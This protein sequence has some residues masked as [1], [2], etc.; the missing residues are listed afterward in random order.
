MRSKSNHRLP[1]GIPEVDHVLGGGIV[2]GN[3]MLLAGPCGV[4]RSTLALQIAASLAR[5]GARAFVAS[6]EENQDWIA[7]RARRLRA[8]PRVAILGEPRGIVIEPLL[9]LARPSRPKLLIVDSSMT[10]ASEGSTADYGRVAQLRAVAAALRSYARAEACCVLLLGP[11]TKAG[12]PIG[13]EHFLQHF[14]V[15]L[16]LDP[17]PIV[18]YGVEASMMFRLL[19]IDGTNARALLALAESGFRSLTEK[20]RRRLTRLAA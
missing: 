13:G 16:R 1:T 7:S 20:Q 18:I 3:L 15:R 4:G 10:V 8:G 5:R 12:E 19:R 2:P 6:G 17:Y 9:R 14:D 11:L